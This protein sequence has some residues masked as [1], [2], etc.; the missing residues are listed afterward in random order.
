MYVLLISLTI[1]SHILF[2]LLSGAMNETN[3]HEGLHS[4]SVPG[5]AKCRIKIL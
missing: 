4:M 5:Q 2:L 1:P 3:S